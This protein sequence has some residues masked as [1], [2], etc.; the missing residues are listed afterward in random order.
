MI[1]QIAWRNIWRSPVRSGVVMIAIALGLSL[2][3]FMMAF[4]WGMSE[5][6]ARNVV[7]IQTSHLQV[8]T[9]SYV[10]EPKMKFLLPNGPELLAEINEGTEVLASAPRMIAGGMLT[11]TKGAFGVQI[12]G[13]DP[14]AEKAV[15]SFDELIIEGSYFD[16]DKRN[17]ILIG[18]SL[19]E[20]VGVKIEEGDS[21]RWNFR[22][23]LVLT[24]QNLNGESTR[25]SFR[26]DGIFRTP[27]TQ[28]D[29][30]NVFVRLQD[31]QKLAEAGNGFHEIAIVLDDIDKSDSLATA[32]E[33]QHTDLNAETWADLAPDLKLIT[34]SFEISMFIFIGIILLALAFGIINSMLMAVLER[35]RELGMLMAVGMN[36]GRVFLMIMLETI[37]LVAV[38]G[39]LGLLM[40]YGLVELSASVGLDMSQF[41]EGVSQFGFGTIVR[42]E[43]GTEYY[44]Q[45]AAMV[46]LAAILS[47]IYPAL[48]AIKLKPVEAIRTV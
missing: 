8:H 5:E 25:A 1:T 23:R 44:L 3:V 14:E 21:V 12:N 46:V 4:S 33:A 30:G 24:F 31:F 38:G 2:G 20:E 26:V 36:R 40:G 42:P 35:T 22:K 41:S 43:L 45:I 11:S 17:R 18:E 29:K 9:A 19:A 37:F 39:P 13:V 32:I 48:R 6:R 28:W 16:P 15:R 47:A 7:D 27:N 10:E 34:E